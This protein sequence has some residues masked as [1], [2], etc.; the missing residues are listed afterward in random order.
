MQTFMEFVRKVA[1]ESGK[2]SLNTEVRLRFVKSQEM[3][4]EYIAAMGINGFQTSF[5][6][7]A[8]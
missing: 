7:K 8:I 3:M 1:A 6:R 5:I 2:N 4:R